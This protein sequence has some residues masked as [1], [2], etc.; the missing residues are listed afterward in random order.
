MRNAWR[1]VVFDV[2]APLATIAAL[3]AIGVLLGWPLWWVS[4]CS[5]L[6]LLVVEGVAINFWLLRR[7]SVTV[8]TDDDAP[9]LRLAVVFLC[10]AAISA[11]VVTGYLRWTT[12]DR[13]F[14]RDSREV[15]HLATGMAETVAS[16]SP[17]APAAAVDRAAAMMVPEH[18]GGFKEQYAKSS[19]D[20][21]RRGVT[22]QAATLA[23]GVEAIGPSAASVAVILRVSQSIPRPA[24]QSSGASAAGDLD[25]AGQR[26]AGAR[27]DADQRS[28]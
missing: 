24:D 16:F 13:D 26:L 11:A 9:G 3:A 6:V 14:N 5:V 23:A 15:V 19:A 7:D 22:A 17:S 25:Q 28:L 1:L 8:G 27:R 20:L 2:L 10:A 4:T 12:P 18:A 21:A